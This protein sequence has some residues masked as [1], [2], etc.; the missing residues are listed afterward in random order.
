M[1]YKHNQT[2][3]HYIKKHT[4]RQSN[5][6]DYNK[7]L[8]NRGWIDVWISDDIVAIAIDSTGLKRFGRDE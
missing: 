3:R 6:S 8:R 1:S 5:Y 2:K 4:Y 7:A